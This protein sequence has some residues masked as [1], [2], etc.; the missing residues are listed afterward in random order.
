[1]GKEQL[2]SICL[3]PTGIRVRSCVV[4]EMDCPKRFRA[5]VFIGVIMPVRLLDLTTG[6]TLLLLGS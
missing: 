3:K 1:M 5:G 2:A 6:L 4:T